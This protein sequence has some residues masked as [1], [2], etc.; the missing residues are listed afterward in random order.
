M[1]GERQ[2]RIVMAGGGTGGHL[3]PGIAV[4]REAL[5]RDPAVTVTFAGTSRG[6][7]AKVIPREGFELDVIRSGGLKGKSIRALGKGVAMLAPSAI[8][9]WR[10]LTRRAPHVVVG[11]GGYSSGPV[12]ALAASRGIPTLLM[13]QNAVPG[14]TNRLLGRLV[15]RAAVTYERTLPFFGAKGI[16]SGNPVRRAFFEMAA[17]RAAESGRAP[18]VLV[19]GGS[20]GAHA[21][22]EAMVAA[23]P[24][25]C[26][27]AMTMTLMHQT[28]ERD[29]ERVRSG[30]REARL[31][32]E[33]EPFVFD[34]D[35][36][37]ARADLVVCRA[38]ATTLAEIAAAGRPA[39]LIPLPTATDDHQRKNAEVFAQAGA[40]EVI[41]QRR[42]SGPTLASTLL[43]LG[44]DVERRERMSAAAR[45]LGRPDAARVI[46]DC[47]FSLA[48]QAGGSASPC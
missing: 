23:A 45:R 30:Y 12:V 37:M 10:L 36:Q 5:A 1:E 16:L 24:L 25:L 8:D 43:A 26:G 18:H 20:Q 31:E 33:V 4:A 13:E 11:L 27:G 32:A 44:S 22:N 47:I 35:R 46:V 42:L 17:P 40:A 41:D 6:L 34:M 15:M 21:I 7:E 28:G 14:L 3:F 39:V 19:F 38:G 48:G 29:L 2:V 9:A